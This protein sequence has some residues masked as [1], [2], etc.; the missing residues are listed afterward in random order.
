MA[1]VVS[2]SEIACSRHATLSP[3]KGSGDGT[4]RSPRA[5]A[6]MPPHDERKE[7]EDREAASSGA[8]TQTKSKAQRWRTAGGACR[9]RPS[10]AYSSSS[11]V[12]DRRARSCRA[13]DLSC[14]PE[15]SRSRR[16][17]G[18]GRLRENG[19]GSTPGEGSGA[20]TAGSSAAD[21]FPNFF[22]DGVS[23][24]PQPIQHWRG[25]L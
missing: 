5:S 9:P 15:R 14:A 8:T 13:S 10:S 22:I 25:G 3:T 2:P 23:E 12:V 1:S 6:E 24:R 7:E 17:G 11:I 18:T 21:R 20:S 19:A 4:H 16:S